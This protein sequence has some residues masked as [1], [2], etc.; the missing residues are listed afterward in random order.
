M[1]RRPSAAESL[2]I[3]LSPEISRQNGSA[4][5]S[6]HPTH[7]TGRPTTRVVSS[8]Q[9]PKAAL[10]LDELEPD[11]LFIRHSVSDVRIVQQRLR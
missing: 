7:S 10:S 11:E 1:A 9:K 4:N 2:R 8:S 5:V 3:P 6:G